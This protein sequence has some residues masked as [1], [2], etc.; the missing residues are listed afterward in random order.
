M[1]APFHKLVT[2]SRLR[3]ILCDSHEPG[4]ASRDHINA[5]EA[6]LALLD[7][8][9]LPGDEHAHHIV[10]TYMVAALKILADLIEQKS[11][12]L[13]C[14]GYN[15]YMTIYQTFAYARNAYTLDNHILN[16]V[17][18]LLMYYVTEKRRIFFA[19]A[20]EVM[21]LH[22][23]LVA[24]LFNG[25]A[26]ISNNLSFHNNG[27][28]DKENDTLFMLVHDAT[29][30]SMRNMAWLFHS[31]PC[32]HILTMNDA[33]DDNKYTAE[34]NHYKG[35]MTRIHNVLS[36]NA[37]YSRVEQ[38][39]TTEAGGSMSF[40]DSSVYGNGTRYATAWAVVRN[41]NPRRVHFV[42]ISFWHDDVRS[43]ISGL[44]ADPKNGADLAVVVRN[45]DNIVKSNDNGTA[46]KY[47]SLFNANG[48]VG[49]RPSG[50]S[51]T[52]SICGWYAKGV[53]SFEALRLAVPGRR[54]NPDIYD[55]CLVTGTT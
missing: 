48:F 9:R 15:H 47:L 37:L 14:K 54:E 43:F 17:V 27:N 25:A 36:R 7:A 6:C 55:L 52:T 16:F 23:L 51:D 20:R 18:G 8:P 30:L 26:V 32:T 45:A 21:S 42:Y 11:L 33:H 19:S 41:G 13:N 28:G 40:C 10:A 49:H 46:Q 31:S 3:G 5:T 2:I 34:I 50:S 29:S 4:H 22:M 39:S 1:N 44:I 38:R 53:A 35:Q 12:G 24:R